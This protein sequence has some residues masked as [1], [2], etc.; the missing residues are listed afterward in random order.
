MENDNID[1]LSYITKH[2]LTSNTAPDSSRGQHHLD[3][4]PRLPQATSRSLTQVFN[5]QVWAP[6][7]VN[8]L[9]APFLQHRSLSEQNSIDALTLDVPVTYW[10][11]FGSFL[12]CI[13]CTSVQQT[14]GE[15]CN[16]PVTPAKV[17][18]GCLPLILATLLLHTSHEA[19]DKEGD[20]PTSSAW[21]RCLVVASVRCEGNAVREYTPVPP[22][23]AANQMNIQTL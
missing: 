18:G 4:D 16:I 1:S 5:G 22:R 19:T 13:I 11:H 2:L 6:L 20:W 14:S 3:K 21:P 7:S 23:P 10:L 17:A 15:G 12:P 8:A 9:L